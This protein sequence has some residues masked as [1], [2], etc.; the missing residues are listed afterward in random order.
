MPYWNVSKIQWIKGLFIYFAWTTI[1]PK[2]RLARVICTQ[3]STPVWVWGIKLNQNYVT[4]CKIIF[5][6]TKD[7]SSHLLIISGG[8][9]FSWVCSLWNCYGSDRGCSRSLVGGS[10]CCLS[11]LQVWAGIGLTP[12]ENWPNRPQG[13]L[14]FTAIS[15]ALREIDY[16][17]KTMKSL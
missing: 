4:L 7:T 13:N 15:H 14:R 1:D 3:G 9:V 10:Y 11:K 5:I 12:L 8:I 17:K 16:N 2:H 6:L